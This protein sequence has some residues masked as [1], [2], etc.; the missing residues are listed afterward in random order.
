MNAAILPDS[1][2][3]VARAG[4]FIMDKCTKSGTVQGYEYAYGNGDLLVVINN[5][6]A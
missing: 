2:N 6:Y 4:G 3:D 5:P 1:S